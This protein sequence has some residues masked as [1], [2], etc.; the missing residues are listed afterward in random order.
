MKQVELM[1]LYQR[2]TEYESEKQ[3]LDWL[4]QFFADLIATGLAWHLQGHYG[5]E[6]NRYIE[7]GLVTPQG[8]VNW[9]VYEEYFEL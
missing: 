8:D 2:V 5:R 7:N 9:D 3:N 6:A 4:V 1:G